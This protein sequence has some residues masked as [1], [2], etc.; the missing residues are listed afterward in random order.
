MSPQESGSRWDMLPG[1][2]WSSAD[3]ARSWLKAERARLGWS[4]RDVDRAFDSTAGKSRLYIGEGGGALFPRA[5]VAR[6]R[7]F[8]TRGDVIPDWLYWIPLAIERAQQPHSV[9]AWEYDH[10][11]EHWDH[12][13][14][15]LEDLAAAEGWGI[16]EKEWTLVE[17]TRKMDEKQ[18]RFLWELASFPQ[19]FEIFE[20][21]IVDGSRQIGSQSSGGDCTTG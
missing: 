2:K 8:E 1:P 16:S 20:S 12:Y 11:P 7:R 5:T 6:V 14:E 3:E 18:K 4:E 15:S 21:M 9:S 10:I 19:Y 13:A 17:M